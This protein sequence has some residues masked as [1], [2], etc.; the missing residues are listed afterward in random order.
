MI[1]ELI[2]TEVE[3]VVGGLFNFG[4]LQLNLN[5]Q[6]ANAQGGNSFFGPGGAAIAANV[7]GPQTNYIG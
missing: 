7:A 3:E 5:E 1:R 4:N 6:V 2:D